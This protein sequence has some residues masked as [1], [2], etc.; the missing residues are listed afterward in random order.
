VLLLMRRE[1]VGSSVVVVAQNFNPSVTSQLWLVRNGVV[2]E[3]DFLPGCIFTDLLVQVRTRRFSL[4]FTPEQF[5]FVPA[6][7]EENPHV[8]VQ[9]VIGRIVRTLPHT[10]YRALGLNFTW[11]LTL[12]EG[13]IAALSRRLFFAAGR[14]LFRDFDAPD[15]SFGAFLSRDLLGFRLKLDVKPVTVTPPTAAVAEQR[16]Q[17]LYNFHADLPE[18]EEAVER[19]EQHLQRWGEA[20]EMARR[21][22]TSLGEGGDA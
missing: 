18:G 2:E 14:P 15:A 16:L 12:E 10:P 8:L 1:L 22:V 19:I 9:D 6:S 4:L 5:Q 3:G 17:F 13:D 7:G 20:A 11:H 21:S